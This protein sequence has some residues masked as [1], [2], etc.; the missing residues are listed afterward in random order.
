MVFENAGWIRGGISWS[1]NKKT[2]APLASRVR[3]SPPE[4]PNMSRLRSRSS[5]PVAVWLAR[6]GTLPPFTLGPVVST[7][8]S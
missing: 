3:I 7:G 4:E 6:K 8:V 1:R 2:S 5:K